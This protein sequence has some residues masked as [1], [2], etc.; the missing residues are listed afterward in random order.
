MN[1]LVRRVFSRD[2][3]GP[4]EENMPHDL[5]KSYDPTAI[6]DRWAEYWVR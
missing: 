6:E 2:Y 1:A 5:P 3:R 4:A